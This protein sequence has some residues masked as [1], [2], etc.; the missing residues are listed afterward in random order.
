MGNIATSLLWRTYSTAADKAL[1]EGNLDTAEQILLSALRDGLALREL[2]YELVFCVNRLVDANVDRHRYS[3][4]EV[5]VRHLLEVQE[6]LLGYHHP[7][8]RESLHTLTDLLR[9]Q[10]DEANAQAMETRLTLLRGNR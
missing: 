7:Q 4:A 3:G 5:I 10:G 8:V 1:A 6:E 2:N 9:L